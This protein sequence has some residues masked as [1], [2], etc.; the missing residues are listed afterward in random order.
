MTRRNGRSFAAI[1]DEAAVAPAEQGLRSCG[2]VQN[3]EKVLYLTAALGIS[4]SSLYAAFG[5]KAGL[6]EEAV[7]TYAERFRSIYR[8]AVEEDDIHRVLEQ[9]LTRSV[10]EFT[11]PAADHPGCLVGSAVMADGPETLDVRTYIADLH[12]ANAQA[13]RARVERAIAEGQL[14]ADTSAT[15]LTGLVQAVWHGLS[16]QSSLGADRAELLA[17]AHLAMEN[18][19]QRR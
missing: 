10:H 13:L 7:R 14:A 5:S 9:I 2:V 4:T 3:G 12:R 11:Q 17:V 6:F 18:L 1:S 19:R 15:A 16:A 8:Q